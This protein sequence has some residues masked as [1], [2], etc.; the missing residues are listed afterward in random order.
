MKFT[1]VLDPLL[2]FP[3]IDQDSAAAAAFTQHDRAQEIFGFRFAWTDDLEILLTSR[4]DATLATYA[5]A[6]MALLTYLEGGS[7]EKKFQHMNPSAVVCNYKADSLAPHRTD[8][9]DVYD[10]Y[11][12]VKEI[13]SA[14]SK[15]DSE[16]CYA[17]GTRPAPASQETHLSDANSQ[18]R[19]VPIL[20]LA[21]DWAELYRNKRK[22]PGN[23]LP[24]AFILDTAAKPI[25]HAHP[26]FPFIPPED[27]KEDEQDLKRDPVDETMVKKKKWH[28]G[29]TGYYDIFGNCWIW[30]SKRGH[31]DV[32]ITEQFLNK[33][34]ALHKKSEKLRLQ[35]N[36]ANLR[37]D[38]RKDYHI[39]VESPTAPTK[40]QCAIIEGIY[41]AVSRA[42]IQLLIQQKG[43]GEGI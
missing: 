16:A 8:S 4:T 5:G 21:Y 3:T 32:Q 22:S 43:E 11:T 20:R 15:T 7:R 17:S 37:K 13:L 39:N 33:L 23:L 29:A 18:C 12:A 42:T 41:K 10:C 34:E 35:K 25:S 31:W 19:D 40:Q 26:V 6:Y 9:Q 30:N 24:N 27:C 36:P 38:K 14:L 1:A 28:G 2:L